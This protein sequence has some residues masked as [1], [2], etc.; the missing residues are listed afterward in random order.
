MSIGT[1]TIQAPR[2]AAMIGTAA[3]AP[4]TDPQPIT[5]SMARRV[6]ALLAVRERGIVT[7]DDRDDRRA[8]MQRGRVENA[9]DIPGVVPEYVRPLF[10]EGTGPFRWAALSGDPDDIAVADE[11]ALEMRA[12]DELVRRWIRP[13]GD[14]V[15]VQEWPARVCWLGYGD[16]VQFGVRVDELVRDGRVTARS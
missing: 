12:D 3:L 6:E 7:F 9:F 4:E 15:T 13:S 2:G 5:H 10:C 11:A 16:R 1:R 8:H 14:H